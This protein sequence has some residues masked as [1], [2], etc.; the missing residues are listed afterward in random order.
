MD[1]VQE[2]MLDVGEKASLNIP[3]ALFLPS[4]GFLDCFS[5]WIG[6]KLEENLVITQ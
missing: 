6:T 2:P 5:R 1:D 4:V 3:K